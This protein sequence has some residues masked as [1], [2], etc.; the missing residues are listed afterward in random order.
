MNPDLS[1][2]QVGGRREKKAKVTEG[3][4]KIRSAHGV[5]ATL[6]Q[7]SIVFV[8]VKQSHGAFPPDE[9]DAF[10]LRGFPPILA[11]K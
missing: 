1:Y 8:L 5:L 11:A 3:V 10:L 7:F 4:S 2:A 6:E 9:Y